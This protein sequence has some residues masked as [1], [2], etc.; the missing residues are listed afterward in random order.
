V[1]GVAYG[2]R[3]CERRENAYSACARLHAWKQGGSGE[4]AEHRLDH[5][6]SKN[7]GV[8]IKLAGRHSRSFFQNGKIFFQNENFGEGSFRFFSFRSVIKA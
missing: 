3:S 8:W 2:I 6:V 5:G 7:S 1:R 4:I